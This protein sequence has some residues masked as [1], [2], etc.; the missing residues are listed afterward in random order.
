MEVPDARLQQIKQTG[1][2]AW[3]TEQ[4]QQAEIWID[5][6]FQSASGSSSPAA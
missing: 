6:E 1:F 2:D 3:F 5:P 4:K